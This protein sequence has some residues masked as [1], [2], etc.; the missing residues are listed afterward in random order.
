MT[1]DQA[2]WMEVDL[3]QALSLEERLFDGPYSVV[4]WHHADPAL[5]ASIERARKIY[6]LL[7]DEHGLQAV[8]IW[9]FR[10]TVL[11]SDWLSRRLIQYYQK[12]Q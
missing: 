5:K 2:C 6:D 10:P 1:N 9:S 11:L 8:A 7:R 3:Q 4:A 12:G